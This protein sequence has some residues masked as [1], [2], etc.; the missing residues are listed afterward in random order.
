MPKY[1]IGDRVVKIDLTAHRPGAI[2]YMAFPAR[3]ADK[4]AWILIQKFADTIR[5]RDAV[6][7]CSLIEREQESHVSVNDEE[8]L[9]DG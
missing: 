1:E 7:T 9:G 4:S 6:W 8:D 5:P 2:A 3:V